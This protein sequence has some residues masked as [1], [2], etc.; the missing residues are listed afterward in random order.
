M[1]LQRLRLGIVVKI[2]RPKKNETTAPLENQETHACSY[3]DPIDRVTKTNVSRNM[4]MVI[5]TDDSSARKAA[6]LDVEVKRAR[7]ARID[8]IYCR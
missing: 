2:F 1:C 8:P 4:E 6:V 5:V 7:Y 3:S